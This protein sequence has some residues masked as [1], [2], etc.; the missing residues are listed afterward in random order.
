LE[1]GDLDVT[2]ALDRENLMRLATALAEINAFP[3]PDGPFG[4]WETASDGEQRWVEHEP[5]AAEVESRAAWKPDPDDATS[6]DHLLQSRLGA[7]DVVPIVS[8]TYEELSARAVRVDVDG[9]DVAVESVSDLLATLTVPRREKDRDRVRQL[10][11]IQRRH[12]AGIK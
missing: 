9:E 12:A 7:I 2:P 4:H 5:T 10:R 11:D 3:D 6:F 8:G 1:P